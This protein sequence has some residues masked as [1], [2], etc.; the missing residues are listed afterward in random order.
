MCVYI[1]YSFV[2]KKKK[3]DLLLKVQLSF[4]CYED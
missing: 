1:D 3:M 4:A 2:K